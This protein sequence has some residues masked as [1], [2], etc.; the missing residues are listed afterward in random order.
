M[1]KMG[2]VIILFVAFLSAFCFGKVV[3]SKAADNM[4]TDSGNQ[5]INDE[6][7]GNA[8]AEYYNSPDDSINDEDPSVPQTNSPAAQ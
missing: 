2:T 1:K 7:Y 3:I 8:D 5:V 4:V 6:G